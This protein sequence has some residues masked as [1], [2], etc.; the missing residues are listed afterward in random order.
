[1]S[2]G[3]LRPEA[4]IGT[5]PARLTVFVA[6]KPDTRAGLRRRG[7]GEGEGKAAQVVGEE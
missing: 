2:S 6:V 5:A 3:S 1:M 4:Y 7:P